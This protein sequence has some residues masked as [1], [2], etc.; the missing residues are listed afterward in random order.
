MEGALCGFTLRI[1]HNVSAEVT[2]HI[3]QIG[4]YLM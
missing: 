1:L 4:L 2:C 3:E